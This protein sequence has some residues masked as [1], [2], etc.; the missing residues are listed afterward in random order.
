MAFWERMGVNL[1]FNPGD[2]KKHILVQN[3]VFAVFYVK[4]CAGYG[5]RQKNR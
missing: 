4:I 3:H 1:K 2:P 5:C